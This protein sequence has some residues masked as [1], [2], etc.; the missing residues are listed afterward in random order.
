MLAA[1]FM[2][3]IED[4]FPTDAHHQMDIQSKAHRW[5]QMCTMYEI[6]RWG[7]KHADTV[8]VLPINDDGIEEN[9]GKFIK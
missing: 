6:N 8:G 5:G 3:E 1:S 2:T 9:A 4:F 7:N